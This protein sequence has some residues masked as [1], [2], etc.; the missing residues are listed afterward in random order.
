MS[1]LILLLAAAPVLDTVAERTQF[2]ETGRYEEVEALC[3]AFPKAYPGKV[4]CI[5]FGTTPQGRKMRALV[6]SLDGV[7]EPQAAKKAQRPVVMLQGGIHA[8]EIDGKDAGFWL[9]RD[10]LNGKVAPGTLAKVT[11]LFVPVFNVDGHERFSPNNRPNQVGPKEMGFRVTSQGL[12][13]NRDYAKADAPEMAAMLSLMNKYDPILF[14]DLHVTDGAK[15]QPDVAVLLEPQHVGSEAMKALGASAKQAVFTELVTRGHLPLEFYPQFL[16]DDDPASGFAQGIPPPRFG[17]AYWAYRNRYGVLV[18]T[19]SWKDYKTRVKTTYDVCLALLEQAALHGPEWLKAALQAD[20][21]DSRRAGQ[22]VALTWGSDGPSETLSFPGYAYVRGDSEVSGTKWVKYDDSKP[23]LWKVPYTAN[24]KPGLQPN[25]PKAGY[26]VAPEHAKWVAEKLTLHG[27]KF[28]T[29]TKPVSEPLST[30][31][32]EKIS[33]RADS[34]EGHQPVQLSG[35]WKDEPQQLAIGSLFV[36]I[37][38]PR[39]TLVMDLL[40]PNA[41]DSFAAWGFFNTH[42]ERK[43]YIEGYVIEAAA[44][45]MLKDPKVKAE[46]DERLKDP[47][48]KKSPAER[49]DFFYRKH[50][51]F[52]P[53]FGVYPVYR[54]DAPP[55]K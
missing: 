18:E 33:F 34:Y 26:L 37:D 4:K 49:L 50:P 25:A 38:Q 46:F 10:L 30:F 31:R 41:P 51:A 40:E 8:G 43:E 55:P 48:F 13:L 35:A 53:R 3:Q 15:F 5:E 19:H 28:S 21:D 14:A 16:K 29:V 39:A 24:V 9:L 45:E 2:T 7:L 36:P 44:R 52:D 42:F 20:F 54:L 47:E 12:N 23:E 1:P 17:T 22:P 6:A 11:L 27:I 32:A